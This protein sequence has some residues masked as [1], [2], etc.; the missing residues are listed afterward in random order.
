LNSAVKLGCGFG[1]VISFFKT[2]LSTFYHSTIPG[3]DQTVRRRSVGKGL[4]TIKARLEAN[5]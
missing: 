3:E 4:A 1:I 2:G 5:A